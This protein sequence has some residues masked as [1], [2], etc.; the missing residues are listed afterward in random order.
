MRRPWCVCGWSIVGGGGDAHA[1]WALHVFAVGGTCACG[2][3]VV[4]GG[5]DARTWALHV[6][7]VGGTCRVRVHDG[8]EREGCRGRGA[9]MAG[10]RGM[11]LEACYHCCARRHQA[12][13]GASCRGW[14]RRHCNHAGSLAVRTCG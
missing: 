7:G 1:H 4:G 2:W 6:F 12:H 13:R 10:C 3:S 8:S 9:R 14:L 5:G 11:Q